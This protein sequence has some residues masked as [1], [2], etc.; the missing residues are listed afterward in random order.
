[1][2][3]WGRTDA[4]SVL[5]LIIAALAMLQNVIRYPQR[6]LQED[7]AFQWEGLHAA[8]NE[9]I[10]AGQFPH[11][12]PYSLAGQRLFADVGLGLL[13]PGSAL[14]R[15]LP[16]P[17]ACVWTY[18]LHFAAL[19]VVMYLLARFILA[20]SPCAALVSSAIFSFGGFA[21]GHTNHLNFVMALPWL[22]LQLLAAAR[23][24]TSPSRFDRWWLL[25]VLSLSM[26]L[27]S[28]GIPILFMAVGL[29]TWAIIVLPLIL[30]PRGRRRAGVARLTGGLAAA[31]LAAAGLTAAQ[32]LPTLDLYSVSARADWDSSEIGLGAVPWRTVA[33]QLIAPGFLGDLVT[34]ALFHL[35]HESA[36]FIGGCGLAF[37][38]V[39]L[40]RP[41]GH[42]WTLGLAALAGIG[43]LLALRE[44]F[45]WFGLQRILPIKMRQPARFVCLFQFALAL[46]AG[47]GCQR[48]L[49]GLRD[50]RFGPRRLPVLVSAGMIFATLFLISWISS[51][52]TTPESIEAWRAQRSEANRAWLSD[53]DPALAPTLM[54]AR[55]LARSV[56]MGIWC[57]AGIV[58]F[59]GAWLLGQRR[60]WIAA[61]TVALVMLE[62]LC[63]SRMTW[64]GQTTEP[65]AL[66]GEVQPVV[67]FLR[68]RL[69]KDRYYLGAPFP[70][71][72]AN[73]GAVFRLANAVGYIGSML[74]VSREHAAL[75]DPRRTNWSAELLALFGVRYIV[76]HDSTPPPNMPRVFSSAGYSVYENPAFPGRAFFAARVWSAALSSA[77]AGVL[78]SDFN[79][80][81]LMF[82][83]ATQTGPSSIAP[84][85]ASD[86]VVIEDEAPGVMCVKT[87]CSGDRAVVISTSHDTGWS[88]T[89]D[90]QPFQVWRADATFMGLIV[91]SGTHEI[92]LRY[93]T[94]MLTSGLL[95]SLATMMAL[96]GLGLFGRRVD[97][98]RWLAKWL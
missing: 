89:M 26:M 14:F 24:T 35:D 76:L 66:R 55:P 34:Q 96:A 19:A 31:G 78:A 54:G 5:V 91:P 16:F 20:L 22:P 53:L 18:A 32:W 70:P 21:L 50:A 10:R 42:A 88:A 23:M 80:R 47:I 6:V 49:E 30:L 39:A 2:H 64:V 60:R 8:A 44:S 71:L 72:W 15:V 38:I 59:L 85:T 68:E 86:K 74:N 27:L 57:A 97:R 79:V 36:I 28:G 58:L 82:L 41:R 62:C 73:R 90:G 1:M 93:R 43:V 46:L 77:I 33:T 37:V 29:L 17:V 92:V 40:M 13:Y 87:Q 45:E 84:A 48:W 4:I 11:W 56:S 25:A 9:Q 65:E 81:G 51:A 61:L 75:I 12:N 98:R 83:E 63:F 69:G 52:G 67:Q 95:V 94:P 3:P 7:I